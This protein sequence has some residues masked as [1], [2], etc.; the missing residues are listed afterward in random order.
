MFSQV[1]RRMPIIP[2]LRR[3]RQEDCCV[4]GSLRYTEGDLPQDKKKEKSSQVREMAQQLRS[5]IV[6][7]K[8]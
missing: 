8:D 3:L 6:L 5:F 4:Q 7:G 2:T 1:W